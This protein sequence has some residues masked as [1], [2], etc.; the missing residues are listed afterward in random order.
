MET[1]RKN[2]FGQERKNDI[3]N[4]VKLENGEISN[5]IEDVLH[6]WK[7]KIENLLNRNCNDSSNITDIPIEQ[8]NSDYFDSEI[9]IEEILKLQ[10]GILKV[11]RLLG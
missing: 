3:P 5:N 2:W 11:M 4:E 6:V 1:D 8:S 7:K 10:C 9:N